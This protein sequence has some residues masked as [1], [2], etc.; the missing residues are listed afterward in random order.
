MDNAA[1]TPP[2]PLPVTRDS[3]AGAA[4]S[5][6]H[7]EQAGVVYRAAH[8]ETTALRAATLNVREREFVSLLGPSGCGK[9]TLLKVIGGLL[10]PTSGSIRIGG[11]SPEAARRDRR[12]GFVF[13]D[14]ALLA[15]RSV[16]GNV[17]L[18]LE[19]AAWGTRQTRHDK[20]SELLE[21]VGLRG[22]ERHYPHQL[23]GGMRQRVAIARALAIDPTVLLMDEPL[24]AL[25]AITRDRMGL[26]LL[27]IWAQQPK[28]VVF[29]THSIT[30]SV[31]LSDRVVVM[32]SRPG[33]V[34]EEVTIDLP[35]PRTLDMRDSARFADAARYLRK[36]LEA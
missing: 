21:R 19:V 13:Q 15:W 28:T 20:A 9:T 6:I 32:S 8:G 33:R 29:V 10:A 23:S 18:L 4:P 14:P 3:T 5:E 11:Q 17:E 16:L 2:L 24:G 36:V 31:L 30:E 12:I 27:R 26:E 7:V 25:D 1:S 35:R 22:F 34:V